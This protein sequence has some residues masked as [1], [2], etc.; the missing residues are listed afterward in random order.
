[1]QEA[2]AAFFG[3]AAAEFV[4]LPATGGP[5]TLIMPTSGMGN[6]HF[7]SDPTRIYA[8]G[9]DGLVSFRWDGTDLKTHLKVLGPLPPGANGS[10]EM[11]LDAGL[12]NKVAEQWIGG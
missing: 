5:V 12:E 4:W 2:G 1:M 11:T 9:R 7:T 8:Y 3:P 6:P 10:T